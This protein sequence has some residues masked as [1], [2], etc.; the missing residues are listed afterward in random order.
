MGVPLPPSNDEIHHLFFV[1]G[2]KRIAIARNVSRCTGRSVF[3]VHPA[4]RLG[5]RFPAAPP[6]LSP[7]SHPAPSHT[8]IHTYISPPLP[9]PGEKGERPTREREREKRERES[10]RGSRRQQK[11]TTVDARRSPPPPLRPFVLFPFPVTPFPPPFAIQI[12]LPEAPPPSSRPCR[13]N[14][15]LPT[16]PR[17]P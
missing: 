6:P 4:A 5:R 9:I 12:Q 16:P 11:A 15:I 13:R 2:S 10:Q 17:P 1:P 14:R 3:L 8:Y 7:T